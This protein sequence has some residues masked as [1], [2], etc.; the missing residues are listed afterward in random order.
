MQTLKSFL[1][2]TQSRAEQFGAAVGCPQGRVT[3][4]GTY[5]GVH[6]EG[7]RDLF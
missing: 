1:D 4:I 2:T 3:R 7:H 5:P 6:A